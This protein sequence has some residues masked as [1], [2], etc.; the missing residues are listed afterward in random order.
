[1]T[2]PDHTTEA[3]DVLVVGGGGAGLTASMLLSKLGV[4]HLLVSALP[5]TSTLPKAHV[6][7]QR[8]ME[9]LEDVGVAD[10]IAA[11]STPAEHMAATAFYAGLAG[12]SSDHGRLIAKLEAWGAGGDDENWRAASARRSLNLPQIGRKTDGLYA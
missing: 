11:R 4:D 5:T 7:N 10:D 2:S 9:I 6:L 8:T 3:V 12:A 1:M